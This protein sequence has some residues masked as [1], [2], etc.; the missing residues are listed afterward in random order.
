MTNRIYSSILDNIL[1]DFHPSEEVGLR[2]SA[3]AKGT[4]DE[5]ASILDGK[6]TSARTAADWRGG[7]STAV[8]GEGILSEALQRI[9]GSKAASEIEKKAMSDSDLR[10]FI[11]SEFH[12]GKT[13]MQV[14][15]SL[16]KLA[17][18]QVFNKT[19]AGE[20]LKDMAGVVGYTYLEPNHFNTDCSQSREKILK[21]GKIMAK[22]V[23]RIAACSN[24][25]SC[26][27]GHCSLYKLPIVASANELKSIASAEAARFGKS[28]SR[29]VLADLHNGLVEQDHSAPSAHAFGRIAGFENLQKSEEK[30][31]TKEHIA[32]S[33]EAKPL[34]EVYGSLSATFG[35]VATKKAIKDYVNSLKTG[36][37]KVVIAHMDCSVLVN[38]LA[39]SNAIV[40]ESKC[41]SCAYRGG[42]H[43]GLTGGTLLSF[44]GMDKLKSAKKAS[45]DT[46]SGEVVLGEYQL[47]QEHRPTQE[48]EMLS[49]NTE[50]I[51]AKGSLVLE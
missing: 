43:C 37:A 23:K 48:I 21:E 47:T 16:N 41:A 42:M 7:S 45:G 25:S 20:T 4:E 5:L 13:P 12:L 32:S 31:L 17:D 11:K 2:K 33:V 35:K 18:L 27:N 14:Q 50:E 36:G 19:L 9:Q 39:S 15:A 6:S 28:A 24:C 3:K 10:S 29:K 40:G 30:T 51:E 46:P 8:A 44:P 38:K 22:S 34:L 1:D 26:K 49:D